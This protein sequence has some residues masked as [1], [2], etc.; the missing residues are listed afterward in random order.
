MGFR[1]RC[2]HFHVVAGAPEMRLQ[3]T[4]NGVFI[5]EQQMRIGKRQRELCHHREVRSGSPKA[6]PGILSHSHS[7]IVIPRAGVTSHAYGKRQIAHRTSKRAHGFHPAV[8][9]GP[10]CQ[11]PVCEGKRCSAGAALLDTVSHLAKPSA[12]HQRP[13]LQAPS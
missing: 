13:G 3:R 4:P 7:R 10:G 1:T 9:D 11:Q 2:R 12:T 5:L 6:P 8:R